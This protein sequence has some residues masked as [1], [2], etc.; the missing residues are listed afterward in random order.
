MRKRQFTICNFDNFLRYCNKFFAFFG[1]IFKLKSF[2]LQITNVSPPNTV[3]T[4]ISPKCCV[5]SLTSNKNQQ[6][7]EDFLFLPMLHDYFLLQ[8]LLKLNLRKQE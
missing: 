7:M 1:S 5:L 2:A 8:L 3:L 6:R 4:I